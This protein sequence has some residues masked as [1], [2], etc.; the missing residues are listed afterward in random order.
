[1]DAN[2]TRWVCP[3]CNRPALVV[4]EIDCPACDQKVSNTVFLDF[5]PSGARTADHESHIAVEERFVRNRHGY[6]GLYGGRFSISVPES[7]KD[8]IKTHEEWAFSQ[9]AASREADIRHRIEQLNKH[10]ESIVTELT[11]EMLKDRQERCQHQGD[12]RWLP[13]E[14][15]RMNLLCSDCF[16]VVDAKFVGTSTQHGETVGLKIVTEK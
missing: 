2:R 14:S 10:A 3:A 1:M 7:F 8:H 4:I 15:G 9:G 13:A 12:K 6:H 11:K 16:K 5:V